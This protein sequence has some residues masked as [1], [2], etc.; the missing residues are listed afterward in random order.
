MYRKHHLGIFL[1]F[2]VVFFGCKKETEVVQEP[3]NDPFK[4][5]RALIEQRWDFYRFTHQE[6][7]SGTTTND[8]VNGV[9]G[10]YF[11]F[12][13]NGKVYAFWD[14]LADTTSHLLINADQMLYAGDTFR[15]VYLSA[16]RFDL[17]RAS[18]DSNSSSADTILLRR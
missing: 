16:V 15:I 9:T 12:D 14:G 5:R 3:D 1:L 7:I 10:D 2:M 18:A 17:G 13:T 4:G 6:T 11:D 8:T